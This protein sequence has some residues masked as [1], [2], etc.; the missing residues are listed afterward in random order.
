MSEN[1]Q[2]PKPMP[3]ESQK[4][5]LFS[6]LLPAINNNPFSNT[7]AETHP[8]FNEI[9]RSDPTLTPSIQELVDIEI[10][11]DDDPLENLHS[12]LFA[13]QTSDKQ[14]H[15]I[16]VNIMENAVLRVI[17]IV[18]ERFNSCS[19]DRCRCDIAAQALNNLSA[20]YIVTDPNNIPPIDEIVDAKEVVSALVHAVIKIRN[21]P[22][23]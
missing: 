20:K 15:Y 7:Y 16:T 17:D 2:T 4:D 3:I 12:K 8:E 23:H 6:K 11:M 13:S 19:C 21:K 10:P 5:L 9:L 14:E 1:N 18:I 22:R